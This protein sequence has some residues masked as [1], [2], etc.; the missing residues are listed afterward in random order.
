MY[1]IVQHVLVLLAVLCGIAYP[2]ALIGMTFNVTPPFSFGWAGSA[3]LILE[4]CMLVLAAT[5]T[6]DWLRAWLAALTVIVL[7]TLVEEIGVRAS[8]P[9]GT[10]FYTNVLQPR[11][12]SQVPLAVSCAWVLVIFA[13][14][15]IVRMGYV[16]RDLIGLRGTLLGATLATSLDLAIEPVAVYIEHYWVWIRPGSFNYYGVPLTN[17]VAWFL[18]VWM[19]ITLIDMQMRLLPVR[20]RQPDAKLAN[21]RLARFV[22]LLLFSGSLFM[23]GLVDF[24]HGY[25]L[26]TLFA[27]LPALLTLRMAKPCESLFPPRLT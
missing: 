11:I 9:F 22:P 2:I 18:V 7:S 26:G 21:G 5:L 23:F 12:T 24:T 13:S 1:K 10:Y 17:F 4:A 3:L 14:Y 6:Y 16:G 15:S 19:L 25:Y 27:A 20:I 8:F